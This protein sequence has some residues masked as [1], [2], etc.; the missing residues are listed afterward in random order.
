[1]SATQNWFGPSG[2]HGLRQVREDRQ[3]MI[4]IGGGAIAPAPMRLKIML[5]HQASN[6]LRIDDK[7]AVPQRCLHPTVAIG[8]KTV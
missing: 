2:G 8:R 5:A 1:M 7:A 6:F 4:A 3:V